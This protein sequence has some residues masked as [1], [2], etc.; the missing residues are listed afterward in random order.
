MICV[1]RVFNSG[2]TRVFKIWVVVMGPN[3]TQQ[4]PPGYPAYQGKCAANSA[5]I[6]GGAAAASSS[7]QA[8]SL[9]QSL[10]RGPIPLMRPSPELRPAPQLRV[11]AQPKMARTDPMEYCL[12]PWQIVDHR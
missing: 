3:V 6:G 4:P 1:T 2:V 11:S 7:C 8:S 10:P 9:V 12:W 5:S